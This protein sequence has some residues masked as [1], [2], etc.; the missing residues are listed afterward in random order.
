MLTPHQD[1]DDLKHL[2]FLKKQIDETMS[3]KIKIEFEYLPD[4]D[5]DLLK[6]HKVI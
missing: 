1:N 6:Q 5:L 2:V 4:D 3:P